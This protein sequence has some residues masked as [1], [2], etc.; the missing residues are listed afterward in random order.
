MFNTIINFYRRFFPKETRVMNYI[1][2]YLWTIK[3]VVKS[4]QFDKRGGHEM[5]YQKGT[6]D[7]FN[8]VFIPNNKLLGHKI[9]NITEE[10]INNMLVS[11]DS[12]YPWAWVDY[13]KK[14]NVNEPNRCTYYKNGMT[15]LI[16]EF[17]GGTKIRDVEY[18]FPEIDINHIKRVI[19]IVSE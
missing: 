11:F 15:K 5:L 14:V 16:Y 9:F 3:C 19:M 17:N 8:K 6:L 10:D 13:Q 12:G 7:L 1:P 4:P 18:C 2:K